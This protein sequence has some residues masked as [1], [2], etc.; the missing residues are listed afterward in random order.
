MS[1]AAQR[2][3]QALARQLTR[4]ECAPAAGCGDREASH[5]AR[6]ALTFARPAS[7]PAGEASYGASPPLRKA[8]SAEEAL[9]LVP[10]GCCITVGGFVGS[11]CPEHLL[12]ALRQRFDRA[13]QPRQLALL[14]PVSSGD[15][16]AGRAASGATPP[17]PC[18]QLR[19]A[20]AA[21]R[22]LPS[23]HRPTGRAAAWT[24]WQRRAC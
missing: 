22:D 13:Q 16:C 4:A 7:G 1:D 9:A 24:C 11:G 8:C 5:D 20:P 10:S 23:L 19:G 12:N 15:R 3:L 2:R 18:R 17:A 6:D 21:A 14:V